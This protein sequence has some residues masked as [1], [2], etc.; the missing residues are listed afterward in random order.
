MQEALR[1]V[2]SRYTYTSVIDAEHRRRQRVRL[3]QPGSMPGAPSSPGGAEAWT[4][5]D[6]S[7]GQSPPREDAVSTLVQLLRARLAMRRSGGGRGGEQQPGEGV[8]GVERHVERPM[9]RPRHDEQH[10]HLGS[11]CVPNSEGGRTYGAID[12]DVLL[13]A[14]GVD[15]ALSGAAS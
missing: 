8:L 12:A 14:D 1:G 13:A 6:V 4:E 11:R 9:E 15:I 2:W 10:G 5:E 3:R 7:L